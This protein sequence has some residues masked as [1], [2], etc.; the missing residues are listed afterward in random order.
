MSAKDNIPSRLQRCKV[1][2][3]T[4]NK[5]SLPLSLGWVHSL[6]I[7]NKSTPIGSLWTTP[8]KNPRH[9]FLEEWFYYHNLIK[10]T[11]DKA[12]DVQMASFYIP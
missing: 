10:I 12:L 5:I 3:V 9:D 11:G 8:C 2:E 4:I 1:M 7:Y 6:C